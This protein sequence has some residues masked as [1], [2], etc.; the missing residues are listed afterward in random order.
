MSLI[1]II[2]PLALLALLL[3]SAFFSGA[4]TAFF[5]LNPIEI[6]RLV[7]SRPRTG[8]RLEVLL[9][10]PTKLLSTIIIGNTVVNVAAASLG[11]VIVEALLPAYGELVSILLM[12]LLLLVFG[13]IA[14]KRLAID[15]AV[16]MAQFYTP[17]FIILIKVLTPLRLGLESLTAV[18][19]GAFRRIRF[20]LS[21]D[22]FLTGIEVGEQEGV[23]DEEE[24]EMVDGII[25]LEEMQASE[26]MTPRVD[27]IGLDLDDPPEKHREIAGR[28]TFRFLPVYQGSLDHPTGFLDVPLF[29]LSRDNDISGRVSPVFFVPETAPLDALLVTMQ[30]D[31]QRVAIVV[32]EYGGTAGLITRG[33][34]LEEIVEDVDNEYGETKLTF[35]ALRPGVWLVHGDTSLEDIDYEL[36]V[37][38]VAEGA[39]RISGWV[40]SQAERIPKIGHVIEAQGCRVT[41]QRVRRNRVTMVLLETGVSTPDMKKAGA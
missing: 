7:M 4:E 22:E 30:R 34:I 19:S 12:T 9:S 21:E 37:E 26:V 3:C 14:P 35:Q 5:S 23:L 6:K 36:D 39:D 8:R 18:F 29:L 20:A 40:V 1:F 17:F 16:A 31:R 15:H 13:E 33:D 28:V 32:D 25:R 11:F 24:R 2:G 10:E 27:V 38:L 41:V